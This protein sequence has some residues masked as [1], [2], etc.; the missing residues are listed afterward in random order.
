[1]V[2]AEEK[3]LKIYVQ[4]GLKIRVAEEVEDFPLR[5]FG[6]TPQKPFSWCFRFSS[7]FSLRSKKKKI[8]K[9]KK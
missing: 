6:Q 1:M 5:I 3:N 2:L 9:N 7:D 8:K 4:Q